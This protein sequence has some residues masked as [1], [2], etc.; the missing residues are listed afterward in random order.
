MCGAVRFNGTVAEI[1]VGQLRTLTRVLL[2]VGNTFLSCLLGDG[3]YISRTENFLHTLGSLTTYCC[4]DK[5]GT[6]GTGTN[7]HTVPST[8]SLQWGLIFR[9]TV[10]YLNIKVP[11]VP[12]GTFLTSYGRYWYHCSNISSGHYFLYL[13]RA[14]LLAKS[15]RRK[16]FLL[17]EKHKV[18]DIPGR[19]EQERGGGRGV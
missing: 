1:L 8:Y 11:G 12:F 14:P 7:V 10:P 4:T 16:D 6:V 17:Q 3:T 18:Q 5:K 9:G 2:S 13:C 15:I 19:V